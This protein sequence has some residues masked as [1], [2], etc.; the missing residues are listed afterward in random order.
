MKF[1]NVVSE[2]FTKIFN[3]FKLWNKKYKKKSASMR[4]VYLNSKS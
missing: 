3:E 4:E 2:S 1:I